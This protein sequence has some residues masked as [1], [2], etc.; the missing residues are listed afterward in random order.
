M[1]DKTTSKNKF[2]INIFKYI[3][4][5]EK[6]LGFGFITLS[7][8]NKI[9]EILNSQPHF[10]K[11]KEI[12]CQE[13]PSENKFK[14]LKKNHEHKHLHDSNFQSKKIFIGGLPPQTTKNTLIN[15][16]KRYGEIEY[17]VINTDK[18]TDKPRGKF[19]IFI[20]FFFFYY[21]LILK[22]FF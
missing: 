3:L 14:F 9:K 22:I 8:Q 17:C 10:I 21:Y 7:E 20:I 13:F 2:S 16:F 18:Y 15:F 19:F 12:E 1:I 4:I 5:I 6:S 11:G